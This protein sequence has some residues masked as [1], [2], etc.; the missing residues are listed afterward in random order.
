MPILSA[1]QYDAQCDAAGLLL[2]RPE[3]VAWAATSFPIVLVDEGQDLKPQRLRM[4]S[5]LA[6]R[7]NLLLAA[8]EF[9]CLDPVLRPNP[10]AAWLRKTCD[11]VV[12]T[13]VH[14]TDVPDLLAAAIAIRAG[15]PP[16]SARRFKILAAKGL[17]MAA[18]FLANAIAWR[19]R[20]NVGVISPSLSG[21]FARDVVERVCQRAC[22]KQGNS[23]YAIRWERSEDDEVQSLLTEFKLG[24]AGT[25]TET[26]A[27]IRDLPESG[28]TRE[29]IG[30]IRRQARAAGV[31][32][33]TRTEVVAVLASRVAMR[34][35]RL[36]VDKTMFIAMTVQQAKNREFDGVVVLWPF[37]VGGDAEHKRRL[38]YNAITRA[39]QWCTVI[40]Q[41][42]E[43]LNAPPFA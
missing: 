33:F 5:A 36:G 18:V 14:R 1:D 23:P 13:K 21:A 28:A 19:G 24:D 26:V 6:G 30:W 31:T 7:T 32:S 22:G 41:S 17:P 42:E 29:T 10:C 43:L 9:Q 20:G 12:L 35:Q 40:V 39:R 8:A 3:V 15:N 27:A 37:Q 25:L 4:I 34:R 16:A 11:P 38:L 2:E